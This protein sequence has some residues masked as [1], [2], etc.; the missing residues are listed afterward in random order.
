MEQDRHDNRTLNLGKIAICS[1]YISLEKYQKIFFKWNFKLNDQVDKGDVLGQMIILSTNS[2]HTETKAIKALA[3]GIIIYLP[4]V[5]YEEE[6]PSEIPKT[7]IR[8]K[9][10]LHSNREKDN[11]CQYC[12][13]KPEDLAFK[14]Q[15]LYYY[16]DICI[17]SHANNN[18]QMNIES[19]ALKIVKYKGK[20]GKIFGKKDEFIT[21]EAF[22]EI[23]KIFI[24]IC[25]SLAWIQPTNQY[26]DINEPLFAIN[27]CN[28]PEVFQDLCT[29]CTE[30][31]YR[32]NQD[33][34][35]ILVP[36]GLTLFSEDAK[37]KYAEQEKQWYISKKKL[38]L[39]LDLD[40]TL[41]HA[42]KVAIK[43]NHPEGEHQEDIFEWKLNQSEKFMIKL[44]PY[45]KEFFEIVNIEYQCYLYTMGTKDYAEF[46]RCV[47]NAE[48]AASIDPTRVIALEDNFKQTQKRIKRM[49]PYLDD[50]VLILDDNRNV[51]I[52]DKLNLIFTKPFLYFAEDDKNNENLPLEYKPYDSFLYFSSKVL[53]KIYVIF[54][55]LI[56]RKKN[57]DVR[58]IYKYLIT[59]LFDGIKIAFTG[60]L[61]KAVPFRENNYVR[62]CI[63]S[64]AQ[65]TE[66]LED[67]LKEKPDIL[68]VK[69]FKRTHKLNL[70]LKNQIPVVHLDWI[71]YCLMY[72]NLLSWEEFRLLP[73][74][75]ELPAYQ[76][77][78]KSIVVQ[79][80][81]FIDKNEEIIINKAI[82]Y[83]SKP[84]N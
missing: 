14:Y 11:C 29:Y 27:P 33:H 50:M 81:E 83:F 74:K 80:K 19:G 2:I 42:I 1:E 15:Y 84:I 61:N 55:K 82:L 59:H 75:T 6:N 77:I 20:I 71:D 21:I 66:N 49:M 12:L 18:N 37:R 23:F 32:N 7:I 41:I 47:I 46:N 5:Y 24:P 35:H 67:N 53:H 31:V 40:N 39:I 4:E 26:F 9:V 13:R 38:I 52:E 68:I 65:V 8:I 73:N 48:K 36:Q 51:W 62:L 34:S 30:L 79:N 57:A 60:F 70:A 44:R 28:H 17:D 25:G 63:D 43:K 54:F 3:T 45:L 10:C 16:G 58:E 72:S 78:E 76:I 56:E 64:G 69:D 22:S